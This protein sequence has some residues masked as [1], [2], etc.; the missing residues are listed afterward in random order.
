MSLLDIIGR[1]VRRAWRGLR[2]RGWKGLLVVL[3]L[4][5]ALA[6][7]A[8]VFSAA[9]AFVFNRVPYRDSSRLVE[10]GRASQS[11]WSPGMAPELVAVWRRRPEVF[12]SFH[13]HE[14]WGSVYLSGGD[15]PRF[16]AREKVTPGLFEMLGASPRWGRSFVE[17][18]ARPGAPPV[19][20][21][22][23]DVARQEFGEPGL[24]V[25]RRLAVGDET[26]RGGPASDTDIVGVMPL[27]FRFPTGAERIWLPL[28]PGSVPPHTYIDAIARVADGI[29]IQ[30]VSRAVADGDPDRSSIWVPGAR[31][32]APSV[33]DPRLRQ[34][35]VL[36]CAAA[37]SLLLIACANVANVELATALARKR[38]A[39]VEMALGASSG[40]LV[41]SALIES[42]LG[43]GAALAIAAGIT[44][45]GASLLAAWLP[46]T[47]T[48]ALPHRIGFDARVFLFM[49]MAAAATWLLTS[50]PVASLAGRANIRDVLAA[51]P[52]IH[53]AS[54]AGT[55]VRHLLTIGEVALTVVLLLGAF[56]TVR[57][58]SA[59]LQIP[60]GFDSSNLVALS[61]R[62]KPGTSETDADLQNRLVLAISASQDVAAASVGSPPTGSGGSIR[63]N[64]FIDSE[65]T[66][67]G[68]V[69]VGTWEVA[70]G[71]FQTMGIP[72]ISGRSYGPDEPAA[73]IV[74]DEAFAR[75]YWPQESALGHTF[76]VGNV[77]LGG[78][79]VRT[80]I[81]VARHVRSS[82]EALAT[83]PS[84]VFMVYTLLPVHARYV[85]LEFM[86]RLTE[87]GRAGAVRSLVRAAAP[88][89]RVR[90]DLIDDLYARLFA[91][92]HFAASIMIAFGVFAFLVAMAGI[93]GVMALLTAGRTREIGVR[94]ALGADRA[95][96]RRLVFGS[97]LQPVAVG[98]LLGVSSAAI[99]A[100][101]AQSLLYGV[102]F[103][104]P[105]SYVLVAIVVM[106]GALI[107]TWQPARRAARVD[108]AVTLRAE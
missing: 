107:A 21:I 10:I 75:K 48:D 18:D 96:I 22:G 25:G 50:W 43:C 82:R 39:A 108:P 45:L 86:V 98:A 91:D 72:L 2:T 54:R 58:Y 3:L 65:T 106:A 95:A 71:Y 49:A 19:A 1:D 51:D 88:G 61:V 9:D 92:E 74:V 11:G 53:G 4:A 62:P 16:I 59:L 12:A 80:I 68:V 73:S 103:V 27:S 44:R 28:D 60:K 46:A 79:S 42:A 6:S 20:I 38:T 70:S 56:L 87:A 67:R 104:D 100:K 84:D 76:H 93:Y 15:Q 85:P 69:S 89:A 57:S 31:Q 32:I 83:T 101:W 55:R 35:F 23:E 40:A 37:G 41:R 7:N 36:L 105:L 33:V 97:S 77:S 24:A 78:P 30:A 17:A 63:G 26:S 8:I 5:L 94:M 34:L 66:S 52:R 102:S 29:S 99:A 14:W 47:L 81:G 13:A 64:V 90:V